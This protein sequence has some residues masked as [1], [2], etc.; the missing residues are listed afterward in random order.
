MTVRELKSEAK[1]HYEAINVFECF[2]VYDLRRFEAICNELER[3]GYTITDEKKL[4]ITK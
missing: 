3:R 2:A 4:S 1:E